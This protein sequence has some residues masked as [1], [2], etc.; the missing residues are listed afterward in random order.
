M[1]ELKVSKIIICEQKKDSPNYKNF[2]N[3]VNE[4]RIKVIEAKKR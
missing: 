3:I 4:K 2:K 1:K